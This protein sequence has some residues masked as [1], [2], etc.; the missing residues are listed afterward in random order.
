MDWSRQMSNVVIVALM[1]IVGLLVV[2]AYGYYTL[3]E[4]KKLVMRE[5]QAAAKAL[6]S[7]PHPA[8]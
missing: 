8:E 1:P 7:Q 4:T 3:H 6:P 5:K 2:I